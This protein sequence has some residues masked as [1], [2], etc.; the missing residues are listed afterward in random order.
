MSIHRL[1]YSLMFFAIITKYR[2]FPLSFCGVLAQLPA[3][4]RFL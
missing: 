1:N 2:K 3:K 4:H